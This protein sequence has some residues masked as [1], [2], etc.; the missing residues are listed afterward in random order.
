MGLLAAV[1]VIVLVILR[2]L[3]LYDYN[4][5]RRGSNLLL[6]AFTAASWA[7]GANPL[8]AVTAIILVYAWY[9]ASGMARLAAYAT[10]V[11][12]IPAAWMAATQAAIQAAQGALEPAHPM[13]V[14]LRALEASLTGLY[15]V[16][17]YNPAEASTLVYRL[18]GCRYSY[19]PLLLARITGGSLREAVEAVHAHR[20]KKT[21]T[22]K[23]L[24][25]LLYHAQEQV[26]RY[27]EALAY[28]LETCNPR[29]LY[30]KKTL[31][32]QAATLATIITIA[33]AA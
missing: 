22:W 19:I 8:A 26:P 12:S 31:I 9:T 23:T 15:L 5:A 32:L 13:L 21:E 27:T 6:L 10:L 25:L 20:L 11:A 1:E 18:G 14:G 7:T 2:S 4:W 30:E 17:F 24:G 33:M 28:R 3:F 16:H 29:P